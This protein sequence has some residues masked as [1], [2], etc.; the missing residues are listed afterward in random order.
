MKIME[1][2]H[3]T[4][5]QIDRLWWLSKSSVLVLFIFS[6]CSLKIL[7]DNKNFKATFYSDATGDHGNSLIWQETGN[8]GIKFRYLLHKGF[9]Y[10]FAGISLNPDSGLLDLHTYRYLDVR[11][12]ADTTCAVNIYLKTYENNITLP[13]NYI[14]YRFLEKTIWISDVPQW[15]RIE[16]SSF[17][18]PQWWMEL[19]KKDHL[20]EPDLKKVHNFDIAT[21]VKLLDREGYIQVHEFI[22]KKDSIGIYYILSVVVFALVVVAVSFIVQRKKKKSTAIKII[23]YKQQE[24]TTKIPTDEERI[25]LCI[26]SRYAEAGYCLNDI[27][28]ESGVH[29]TRISSIIKKRYGLTFKQYINKIKIEEAK[30]LLRETDRQILDIALTVGYGD[31]SHFNRTFKLYEGCSPREFRKH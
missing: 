27:S 6:G 2:W 25:L 17:V 4:S 3:T 1:K 16:L 5:H 11:L 14:T 23:S 20:N 21:N 30:R 29:I 12:S 24:A 26:G 22:L 19:H 9:P 18:T 13:E 15:Y 31:A 8:S 7:P 10:P 28:K